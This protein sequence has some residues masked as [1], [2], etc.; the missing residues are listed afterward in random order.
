MRSLLGSKTRKVG[1]TTG[2]A[3]AGGFGKTTLAAEVCARQEIRE[4]F[5]WI[6]WVTVGQEVRGAALADTINDITERIDGQ[7]PGLTSPE[8]AGIRLGEALQGKGRSLLVVDDVWSVEQLRPFLSAGRG[9]T[10]L[11][12]TRIPDLLPDD[13]E[14]VEVDQMSH[15]QARLLVTGG[16]TGLPETVGEQLLDITGRWPLA[17]G[18]ANATLRRAARDGADVAETADRLLRRLRDL[19]PAALDV[20]DA[21]RRDRAV[22]ATLESSLGILGDHRDR[23][24]ELAIFP[25]D[26]E[27]PVDLV[28]LFWKK[29]AGL[30]AE[31][32]GRL[33]HELAE[34]SLITW[35]GN[36][37]S[38]RLHDVIRTYLRHECGQARLAELHSDLLE[39]VASTLPGPAVQWWTLPVSAEYLW[40]TLA[41]H[42]DGA[43]RST[44]LVELVTAPYWVIGKLRRFGPVAVAED[45][46][47]VDTGESRELRRFLDQSGH[48]LVPSTP[49]HAVVNAL[50]QRLPYSPYLRRIRRTAE[51]A[52]MG[53]PRLVCQRL[54]PDLPDPALVRV[55]EGHEGRVR[56]CVFAPDNSWLMTSARDSIR[57]WDP[58]SGQLIRLLENPDDGVYTRYIALSPD[59]R[60]LASEGADNTIQLWNTATWQHDTVLRGHQDTVDRFCFS[61]D[62]RTIVSTGDD[63]TIRM[64]DVET[65]K[66][67][68]SFKIRQ[69]FDACAYGPGQTLVSLDDSGLK[70]WDLTTGS[71][72]DL[73]AEKYAV[74]RA[75]AV[76]HDRNWVA[77]PGTLGVTVHNLTKIGQSPRTLRH[78]TDLTA[79]A[80]SSDG[81]T[82]ATGSDDGLLVLWCTEKWRPIGQIAA[83]GSRIEELAFTLDG[84]V[85]ASAGD[86]GTVRLWDPGK[87][88]IQMPREATSGTGYA[89]APS[90]SWVAVAK[91]ESIVIYDPVSGEVIDEFPK[92]GYVVKLLAIGDEHLAVDLYDEISIS[93]AGNWKSTR[94]LRHPTRERATELCSG[95]HLVCAVDGEGRILLWDTTTWGPPVVLEADETGVRVR[96]EPL[97]KSD[98]VIDRLLRRFKRRTEFARYVSTD[99]AP[100]G[101][102]LAVVAGKAVHILS[103]GTWEPIKVLSFDEEADGATWT[104]DGRWLVVKV[105]QTVRYWTTDSWTLSTE[106]TAISDADSATAVAWSPDTSLLATV[107]DNRT[108]RIHDGHDWTRLTELRLDGEL[109]DCVWLTNRRLVVSG[110]HGVYWFT[111]SS[112]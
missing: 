100:D 84:S 112:G 96:K 19:G 65:G 50:V 103:A 29:T 33:C 16:L 56:S 58:E 21:A 111:Y 9:C 23:F 47:L 89:I 62:G 76:S 6:D 41:Y 1:I 78:H 77:L 27:V 73:P 85:L 93:E 80:F 46:A 24:V 64:W 10:L 2:L 38:L 15:P 91:A 79:A 8:Q 14:T 30:S 12:T 31:D 55:L 82:L 53:M 90:G 63:R 74:N 60:L 101:R 45:L 22:A 69:P 7:R 86:D 40:R 104:P 34:L 83:H 106:L 108:L 109:A 48:L 35:R 75:F 98:S 42:L 87:A 36:R 94:T 5:S 18:L 107:S 4:E 102:M 70:Q 59:G 20:T 52:V 110:G 37:S 43:G 39:A 72:R 66:Q 99:V 26:T 88:R 105:G 67:V 68:R 81:R 97:V 3:G 57:I 71:H 95:G 49:D 17:L 32:A 13:A 61:A 11:V 54:M 92:P 28:I 51:S 25:E 44:E